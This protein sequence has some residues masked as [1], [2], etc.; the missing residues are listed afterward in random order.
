MEARGVW[1]AGFETRLDDGRGHE[2]TIDLPSDEGGTNVG[3]SGLELAVLSLAG[4]INTIFARVAAKRKLRFDAL[5]VSLAADRPAGAPTIQKVRGTLTVQTS[6]SNEEVQ[7][8]VRLTLKTCPV[9]VLFER[10]NI[11][12]EVTLQITPPSAAKLHP[13]PEHLAPEPT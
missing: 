5:T 7:T 10:A 1:K 6:A 13:A 4:C 9:G 2:V 11:P 12:V 3:T 8:V